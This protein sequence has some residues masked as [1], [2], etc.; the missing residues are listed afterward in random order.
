MSV[1]GCCCYALSSSMRLLSLR[2]RRGRPAQDKSAHN[3]YR[4]AAAA[5][6]APSKKD[7]VKTEAL[8]QTERGRE[9]G[10]GRARTAAG[11]REIERAQWTTVAGAGWVREKA[12]LGAQSLQRDFSRAPVCARTFVRSLILLYVPR[13]FRAPPRTCTSCWST[14]PGRSHPRRTPRCPVLCDARVVVWQ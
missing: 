9:G 1:T 4:A 10:R 14:R 13:G 2:R 6:A 11:E 8:R 12:T 3:V 7:G 5:A